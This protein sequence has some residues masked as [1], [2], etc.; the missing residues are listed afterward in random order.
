MVP[1]QVIPWPEGSQVGK[2]DKKYD[3]SKPPNPK[4]PPYRTRIDPKWSDL[5]RGVAPPGGY[6]NAKAPKK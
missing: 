6:H 4:A 3:K 2:H 5:V 1:G